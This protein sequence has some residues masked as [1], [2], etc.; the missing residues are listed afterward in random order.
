MCGAD[1]RTVLRCSRCIVTGRVQ[2]VWFRDSTRRQAGRLRLKGSAT[3]LRDGSVEVIACGDEAALEQLQRW[4]WQ[5]PDMAQ[6][7]DVRCEEVA[8]ELPPGFTIG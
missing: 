8:L 4:L 7:S 6:V 5:G 1:D 3:N 2:G